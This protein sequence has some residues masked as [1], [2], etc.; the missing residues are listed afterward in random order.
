MTL[1]K[2]WMLTAILTISG[3]NDVCAQLQRTPDFHD[4]YTLSEVVVL[5]RHNIRSPLSGPDSELGRMT[6]HE[7]FSWSSAPSELSLRGGVLETMM[8]QYFRKW[9]VSERLITE[10]EQPAEGAVRFYANSKQRTIATAQYFSSGMFPVANVSIEYHCK[11]GE[12]DP[13]FTPRITAFSDNYIQRVL[14]QIADLFGGGTMEGVGQKMT[15]NFALVADVI[16]LHETP[17]YQNGDITD[18]NTEDTQII[19]EQDA[20]PKMTGG[21]N[22]AGNIADALMLQYYEEPDELKAA[23]G[24]HLT[25]ED[26]QRIAAV[27]SWYGDVLNTAPLLA[28]NTAHPLL[29]EILSELQ[30]DGRRFSFLCGHDVNI[31]TVLAAL[32]VEDYTLPEAIETRTPIGS[33]LVMEKWLG[34][35]GREYIA[36]NL[37][38]QSVYQLRHMSLLSLQNPPMVYVLHFEGMTANAD[39][40]YLYDDFVNHMTERISAYDNLTEATA[41]SSPF[42]SRPLRGSEEHVQG[43]SYYIN[44]TPATLEIRDIVIQDGEKTFIK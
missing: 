28:I 33:K 32:G 11:L 8:G 6:S 22:T 18:F 42:N 36:V 10:N 2:L 39:G 30:Y 29:Q 19:L 21:L 17:A 43:T 44:G 24:H 41:I 1:K 4:K 5:S 9:L 16:D 23:F 38:Y 31:G 37:C 12:T 13:V 25:F 27:K 34:K 3:T 15:E 7:W 35:D 26:W 20:E 40:L 14:Q